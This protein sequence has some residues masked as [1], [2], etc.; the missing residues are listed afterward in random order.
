MKVLPMDFLGFSDE[1][2]VKNG[3]IRSILSERR[4]CPNHVFTRKNRLKLLRVSTHYR[5]H[6]LILSSRCNEKYEHFRIQYWMI[7]VA[8]DRGCPAGALFHSRSVHIGQSPCQ[9]VRARA[10][11]GV[12]L[13]EKQKSR[14]SWH[15]LA[16]R[17]TYVRKD[18]IQL[19]DDLK[20][21]FN[22]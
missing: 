17:F 19:P 1:N 14:H 9:A 5:W 10:L 15:L 12:N 20:Q 11:I 2:D 22:W 3:A 4:V 13:F 21:H 8:V 18:V 16:N 6:I 7:Q